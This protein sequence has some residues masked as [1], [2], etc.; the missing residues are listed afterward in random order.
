MKEIAACTLA[1]TFVTAGLGYSFN[2]MLDLTKQA[3]CEQ[4]HMCGCCNG[5]GWTEDEIQCAACKGT[6]QFQP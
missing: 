1:L 6:G 5:A 2:R 4:I 3:D